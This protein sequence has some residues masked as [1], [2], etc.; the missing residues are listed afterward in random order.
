M[1]ISI[2]AWRTYL[3]CQSGKEGLNDSKLR[4]SK[5]WYPNANPWPQWC[6]QVLRKQRT[7]RNRHD[8]TLRYWNAET[9]SS[10][11]YLVHKSLEMLAVLPLMASVRAASSAD[12][13]LIFHQLWSVEVNGYS[14]FL[15][16]DFEISC[17][18]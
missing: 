6:D 16:V 11:I 1:T 4:C 2:S 9:L 3:G 17:M 5:Q 18:C 14:S 7:E 13:P 10:T 8:C 15:S 12:G